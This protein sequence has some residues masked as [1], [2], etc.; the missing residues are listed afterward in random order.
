M[1]ISRTRTSPSLDFLDFGRP[2]RRCVIGRDAVDCMCRF[3][4]PGAR[5]GVTGFFVGLAVSLLAADRSG[6]QEALEISQTV[7]HFGTDFENRQGIPFV[8][9]PAGQRLWLDVEI[10]GGLVASEKVRLTKASRH[11]APQWLQVFI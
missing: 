6:F 8:R 2:L 11:T 9:Q 7:S 10:R 5:D 3:L 1:G 4:Q